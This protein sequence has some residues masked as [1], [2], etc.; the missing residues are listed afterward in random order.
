MRTFV[1]IAALAVALVSASPLPAE[2]EKA[3]VPA[4]VAENTVVPAVATD[5]AKPDSAVKQNPVTDAI[6]TFGQFIGN[7]QQQL[8]ALPNVFAAPN[9]DAAS[10]PAAPA[11]PNPIESALS[12]VATFV[13]DRWTDLTNAIVPTTAAPVK[14]S[15][16]SSP[17]SVAPAAVVPAADAEKETA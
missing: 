15:E 3:P 2:D 17:A 11:G 16:T 7:I 8:P 13:Q 14:T 1:L 4:V 6:N 9:A 10:A 5:E 12:N